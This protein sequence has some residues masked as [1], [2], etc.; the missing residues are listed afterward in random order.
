MAATFDMT[1][2]TLSRHCQREL[3]MTFMEWRQRLRVVSALPGLQAGQTVERIAQDTGY[4]S[5]SAFIAMFR[6]MTGA[7]PDDFRGA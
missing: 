6:Q 2:R 5:A 1:E 4:G 7:T 3:G